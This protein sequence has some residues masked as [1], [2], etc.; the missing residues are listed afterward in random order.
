MGPGRG[1]PLRRAGNGPG[2]GGRWERSG[3][4]DR[5]GE[6]RKERPPPPQLPRALEERLGGISGGGLGGRCGQ[7]G[8][9]WCL[10][11]P[12]PSSVGGWGL[13]PDHPSD[14]PSPLSQPFRLLIGMSDLGALSGALHLD[15]IISPPYFFICERRWVTFRGFLFPQWTS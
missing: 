6:G 2:A 14:P 1:Q 9:G 8:D 3:G 7:G 5:V 15:L 10:G 4:G 11:L 13:F 12:S